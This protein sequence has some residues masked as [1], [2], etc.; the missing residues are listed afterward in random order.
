MT[1]NATASVVEA[2]LASGIGAVPAKRSRLDDAVKRGIDIIGALAGLLVTALVFVWYR[3]VVRRESPGPVFYRQVRVGRGGRP[4]TLYKFRS[5][6]LDAEQQLGTLYA[7]NE[8]T[9]PVFKMRN[10]PRIFPTGRWLRHHYL[11][12]LPQFWNVL[13]GDMSLI[14]PR[15]PVPEE[16]ALYQPHHWI[17]LSVKPGISGTWQTVSGRSVTDFEEIVRLDREYIESWSLGGDCRLLARTIWKA[18]RGGGW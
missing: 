13:R 16:V 1:K 14:G 8:M 9:G 4:F 5:M 10:D 3:G 15:P 17:R 11:D 2:P 18:I 6:T 12:E 7:R